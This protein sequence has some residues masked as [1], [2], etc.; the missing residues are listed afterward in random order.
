MCESYERFTD[1]RRVE[2][3]ARRRPVAASDSDAADS[4]SDD[5]SSGEGDSR[6][7]MKRSFLC[8]VLS[9]LI[10]YGSTFELVQYVYDLNLW[11][12]L[13]SK[14]NLGVNTPMR[15]LMKGHSF[16]PQYWRSVHGA[17]V[18]L[19]AQVG[20]PQLLFTIA[21]YEYSFKYHTWVRDELHKML[22]SR[23]N[24][25][26]AETLHVTHVLLQI[27]QGLL[28]GSNQQTRA[29]KDR[30]WQRHVLS[31]KDGSD[32]RITFFTRVEFQ[33]GSRKEGTQRY[34][35]SGRPHLHVLLWSDSLDKAELE[36]H[37]AA[38]IPDEQPLSNYV[39]GSQ[40]DRDGESKWPVHVG[41][42]GWLQ[43]EGDHRATLHLR[44]NAEE[45]EQGTRA[46]FV[47]VMDGV[48][49]HQDIQVAGGQALLMQYVSKY[50]S[51]F[52][53]S[54]YDEWMSDQA[55]ANSVARRVCFEYHPYE[56]EMVLQLCGAMFRQYQLGTVSGGFKTIVAPVAGASAETL[57]GF[58]GTYCKC[59]WRGEK[60]SLLEW[61]R[62]TNEAG[63]IVG[64]L[65]QR[66]RAE[67]EGLAFDEHV[68]SDGTQSMAAF[69]QTLRRAW[70]AH[71][72]ERQAAAAAVDDG[73]ASDISERNAADS[74]YHEFAYEFV[75]SPEALRFPSVEEFARR[76]AMQGEK[77][78]SVEMVY[79]LNDKFFGQWLTMNVPFR[80]M[81][82]FRFP[83]IDAL[84]PAKYRNFAIALKVCQ[85]R[86]RMPEGLMNFWREP[87][88]IRE[89]LECKA[90]PASFIEDILKMVD[91]RAAMVE[92]YLNGSLDKND[93]A[94]E[95]EQEV[96]LG[97]RRRCGAFEFND[98]QRLFEKAINERVERAV[99]ANHSDDMDEADDA[100][101]AAW[102]RN[103]PLV[104]LGKPG[105]G[106]TTV[107]LKCIERAA[108]QGAHVLFALPTAQL[109]SRLR[110]KV[111]ASVE[112]AE[113]V[114]V[115]TCHAA[116]KF[117]EPETEVL[118]MMTMYD[119]VFVDEISL[120]DQPQFERIYK[121]WSVAEKVPALVFLGDKFQLPGV[122]KTRPWDSRMWRAPSCQHLRLVDS[123][124]CKEEAF[125]KI[126]DALRTDMP[127][128][129]LLRRI[130]AGRKAWNGN[131]PPQPHHLKQLFFQ[132]PDTQ[133]VTCSRRGAA[134]V[135]DI[136]VE[137]LHGRKMQL[138]IL[139]GDV[140]VNP[141]NY[142]EGEF[143]TDKK[144]IPSEVKI[145]KGMK[146]FLTRNLRKQ[147]DYVNGMQCV[148]ENYHAQQHMLRVRTRTGHRLEIT[149]WTDVEKGGVR[150]YP[151]RAGYASTI[152]KVQGD[153][154]KHITLWLDVERMPA[155]G[156]TALSR[157]S[158]SSDY[159]IGGKVR[160][161]HFVPATHG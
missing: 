124:R 72:R 113:A 1:C 16:S 47:D 93:E 41:E 132:H 75:D 89:H 82:E 155:A 12:A 2:R 149:P 59:M 61:L 90:K 58:V 15:L 157:V 109:A 26:F 18:D 160:R 57:P 139:P 34:E 32:S 123:W 76:Y 8:K 24:L 80:D 63:D 62:K 37:V 102:Q 44:Q 117:G 87:D 35:G 81:K 134:M 70:R 133:I 140:D 68:R 95:A 42:E 71:L 33:D 152:H 108:R 145:Y 43:G 5:D 65:K 91:G 154:F 118:P 127:S 103:Q 159:L 96:A 49:C 135:N 66:H 53:D 112:D 125:Q 29:R 101:E 122:G 88:K 94:G 84:V 17:L 138:A 137:A 150:Y 153:E 98:R 86:Q 60:M 25:P 97:I 73:Q 40:L 143:R 129:A 128:R 19:V 46:Y 30:C 13:G 52:S 56:P 119:A 77:L 6:H 45:H 3:R 156:Y 55:S 111:Q 120:L 106:K 9:P 14:K 99:K 151:I 85:D 126:L 144:A 131:A 105:T 141:E 83:E 27:V 67:I 4:S 54:S 104:C 39:R 7:S 48:P 36:K 50:V 158:R 69:V 20:L 21:P 148:V 10:G 100:R 110:E 79:E 142:S 115:D 92:M 31:A 114:D 161:A 22:R 74:L 28:T 121:L 116:F 130:C 38:S 78:V 146:L 136:A 64:W 107:V 147:D 11:T 23:M 51:K